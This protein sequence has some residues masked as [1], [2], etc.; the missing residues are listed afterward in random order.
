M[1]PG[2]TAV[3]EQREAGAAALTGAAAL[4]LARLCAA[5]TLVSLPV[6]LTGW[7]AQNKLVRGLSMGAVT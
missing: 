6:L 1:A 2:R 7:F 3:H 5:A 4:F